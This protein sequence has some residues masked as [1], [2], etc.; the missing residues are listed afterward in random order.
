MAASEQSTLRD[1][2]R[3]VALTADDI[4]AARTLTWQRKCSRE[5]YPGMPLGARQALAERAQHHLTLPRIATVLHAL[6]DLANEG[7]T[8]PDMFE[9]GDDTGGGNGAFSFDGGA[10]VTVHRLKKPDDWLAKL[11][12]LIP[13][14]SAR[15]DLVPRFFP[16]IEIVAPPPPALPFQTVH[17]RLGAF[18]KEAPQKKLP[19]LVAEVR[20]KSAGKTALVIVHMEHEHAF[21]GI[22]GVRTLHH[23]DVAGDDDFGA[24]DIVFHIGGPFARPKQI[25]RQTS[26]E[27]G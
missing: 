2:L 17:Q 14:A 20:L 18:G 5:M 1:A 10:F 24:V 27:A 23:G 15:P 6:E 19:D 12:I 25:A 4:K 11:P 16:E 13:S 9:G 26:A 7:E 8:T 22:P 3:T 21:W